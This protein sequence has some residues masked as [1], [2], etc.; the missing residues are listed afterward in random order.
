[1]FPFKS[2]FAVAKLGDFD[3]ADKTFNLKTY[4]GWQEFDATKNIFL[5]VTRARAAAA[6]PDATYYAYCYPAISYNKSTGILTVS[7][8]SG[9]VPQ[10]VSVSCAGSVYLAYMPN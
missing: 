6:A 10:N 4:P 2:D 9:S 7:G 5:N 3:A 8:L 1:M